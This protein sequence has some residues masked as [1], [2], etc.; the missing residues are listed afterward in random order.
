MFE[1]NYVAPINTNYCDGKE[2][3]IHKLFSPTKCI[4]CVLNTQCFFIPMTDSG[5]LEV[6]DDDAF[7]VPP[8]VKYKNT[9]SFLLAACVDDCAGLRI[10]PPGGMEFVDQER[11][12]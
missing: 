11:T 9:I 2:S 8:M 7:E 4:I 12:G 10:E 3:A 6:L 5:F 1:I